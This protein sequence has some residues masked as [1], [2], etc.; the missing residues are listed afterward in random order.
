MGRSRKGREEEEL[1]IVTRLDLIASYLSL[2]HLVTRI[3]LIDVVLTD[4]NL[5][6]FIETMNRHPLLL[7]L[8][9]NTYFKSLSLEVP[10][11]F[12]L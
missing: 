3:D 12:H 6:P 7:A 8:T 9:H 11:L 2:H 4:L 1:L 5:I 10:L